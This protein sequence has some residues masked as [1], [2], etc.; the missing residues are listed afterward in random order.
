M[1]AVGPDHELAKLSGPGCEPLLLPN[2]LLMPALVNAHQHGRGVSQL[3]LGYPDDHLEP[4]IAQRVRR[5][6]PDA[7]ALTRLAAVEMLRNGV[8]CT[9]HA[10][11]SYGSGDYEAES[12]DT[13]QAYVDAGMRVTFCVGAMDRGFLV[14]PEHRRSA[15]LDAMPPRAKEFLDT[16][17]HAPYAGGA[18][19]TIAL[20]RR[21]QADFGTHPL[22]NLAYGPAGPEW[23]SD[24]LLAALT[25]DANKHGLGMHMHLLESPVQA[26]AA[27]ESHPEGLL[28]HLEKVG[29]LGP[30]TVIAHGVYL[31]GADIQVI[32][33][34]RTVL[35]HNPGSNLRL[36]NGIAPLAELLSAGVTVA[37]GTDNCALSDTEDLFGE[38]RLA[39]LLAR[40]DTANYRF[41]A[42][43]LLTMV[44]TAGARAAFASDQIGTIAVGRVADVTAI[45]LTRVRGP[46]LDEDMPL[47]DVLVQRVQGRD[48]LLTMVAGQ[49]RYVR[50]EMPGQ[51]LSAVDSAAAATALA[52]RLSPEPGAAE[53]AVA[54]GEALRRVHGLPST[55]S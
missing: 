28:R 12:R 36:S 30:R 16:R 29:A 3:L 53:A 20:M 42:A 14:Y 7:Y 48:V 31:S 2:S 46:Y 54:L 37:V 49:V 19:E 52:N 47:L 26:R 5:G 15:L 39:D 50:P 32:S 45:D 40:R 11:Y 33:R 17:R 23:V 43:R 9:V 27:R 10:N 6:A 22:V 18:E 25:S 4:W 13:I 34:T 55:W 44:T 24:N 21:L 38:L 35:A 41:D 1:A 8:G 51:V